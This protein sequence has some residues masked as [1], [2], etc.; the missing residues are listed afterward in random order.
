MM[1]AA[2][3]NA[4]GTV[5]AFLIKLWT[6]VEDPS[7]DNLIQWDPSGTSF[8]VYDQQSFSREILPLYFKHS[9]IASFIRQLNMYGF[10]KVAHID[11]GGLKIEKDDLQ[12]QHQYFQRGERDLLQYIKRKVS[13]QTV[14]P[15]SLTAA[16]PDEF[17]RVLT[18]VNQVKSK[19]E[20]MDQNLEYIK[21]ENK[22]LWREVAV[23]RQKHHKQQQ[24]VNKL[25]QFLVSLVSSNRTGLTIPP[26]RR[27]PLAIN[28]VSQLAA[29]PPPPA[30]LGA[31]DNRVAAFQ[32][33]SADL[34]VGSAESQG[35]V[36]PPGA[37]ALDTVTLKDDPY[38][39][40]S[41]KMDHILLSPA[42]SNAGPIIHE[43]TDSPKAILVPASLVSPVATTS[44]QDN[45]Q[46]VISS[47]QLN[48]S[49]SLA[50]T[51]SNIVLGSDN[52]IYVVPA[53]DS[54]TVTVTS[55][56]DNSSSSSGSMNNFLLSP[57]IEAAPSLE[58][59][60][61]FGLN[62]PS[63]SATAT[64][65]SQASPTS[66]VGAQKRKRKMSQTP[67][68]PSMSPTKRVSQPGAVVA[69][70]PQPQSSAALALDQLATLG[71]DEPAK[72]DASLA[73]TASKD[74]DEFTVSSDQLDLLSSDLDGVKNILQD[75]YKLDPSFLMELF[76][77]TNP[78]PVIAEKDLDAL[79]MDS[80]KDEA[81]TSG[82]GLGNITGTE[83]VEYNPRDELFPELMDDNIMADID[84][85]D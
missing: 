20:S 44:Q 83:L 40:E 71:K 42:S 16:K 64:A 14:R 2:V 8:H 81:S 25:I 28:D 37:Q 27:V 45:I 66:A 19:Q 80:D 63:A 52:Q 57:A 75:H 17:S 1:Y 58:D 21:R 68:E 12:F 55:A 9:N 60:L 13:N 54:K 11:Q 41:P 7:T 10:R 46:T 78:W 3:E 36:L 32:E 29:S 65:S 72:G 4:S 49:S 74:G 70:S 38:T 23:L 26:M 34:S 51:T 69:A 56:G 84:D 33:A 62:V 48:P 39:I 35:G 53:S 47:N 43:L 6:L 67:P 59:A 24:I 79:K 31:A 85:I 77:S 30:A 61:K 15:D 76:D 22:L 5:P 50:G 82:A 18:D 73:V